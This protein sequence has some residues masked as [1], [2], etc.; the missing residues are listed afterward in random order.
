MTGI[1]VARNARAV[2]DQYKYIYGAKGEW[3]SVA[4]VEELIRNSP[5]YFDSESKK[6]AARANAGYSCADCSGYVSICCGLSAQSTYSLYEMA[7]ERRILTFSNGTWLADGHKIPYGAILW[8][9]KH[10]GIY[11]GGQQVVEARS[12]ELNVT[13]NSLDGR[14]FTH[15]LLLRGIQYE[16]HT[17]DEVVMA[18]TAEGYIPWIGK[19]INVDQV[20]PSLMYPPT[21][22]AATTGSLH[23][24][25]Q[26]TIV[27]SIG[28]YYKIRAVNGNTGYVHSYYV[29]YLDAPA[30]ENEYLSWNGT[31][32]GANDHVNVRTGPGVE[33]SL[34]PLIQE[35]P[36][37]SIVTV[38]GENI[39]TNDHRIWY[40]VTFM[41]NYDGYIRSDLI[42]AYSVV[43]YSNWYGMA[44]SST[45]IVNIRV[46]ATVNSS[47][48]SLHSAL[49]N[50][51]KVTVVNEISGNDGYRWYQIEIDGVNVGYCRS[52]LITPYVEGYYNEWNGK[53]NTTTGSA[54]IRKGPGTGYT[55]VE[56]S[57]YANGTSVHVVGEVL[58]TDGYIWYKLT[59]AGVYAGYVRCDLVRTTTG[60]DPWYATAN[61]ETGTLNI[62]IGPGTNYSLHGIVAN[63]SNGTKVKV[64]DQMCGTDGRV[65]Y[66]IL[67]RDMYIGYTRG[68]LLEPVNTFAYPVWTGTAN[69]TTGV[70]NVRSGPSTTSEVIGSYPQLVNGDQF[71]V[72]DQVSAADGYVWFKI[73]ILNRYV[74]FVRSDLVSH[75]MTITSSRDYASWGGYV[76]A[77][78]G[79]SYVNIRTGAGIGYSIVC[80][81]DNLTHVEVIGT[82]NG[83][84]GYSWYR[85]QYNGN[86]GYI[87]SDLVHHVAS[88]T[89]P[90]VVYSDG[91]KGVILNSTFLVER[92]VLEYEGPYLSAETLQKLYKGQYVTVLNQVQGMA[93]GK[94]C[95]VTAE[96]GS[97]GFVPF[98]VLKLFLKEVDCEADAND[99]EG[100]RLT[101]PDYAFAECSKCGYHI[102]YRKPSKQYDPNSYR[103]MASI[104][105][106]INSDE[107]YANIVL[108][109]ELFIHMVEDIETAFYSYYR[110]IRLMEPTIPWTPYG[111]KVTHLFCGLARHLAYDDLP[112]TIVMLGNDFESGFVNSVE[113]GTLLEKEIRILSTGN[114]K[115]NC[116]LVDLGNW[117]Y[118]K[119]KHLMATLQGYYQNVIGAFDY[120]CGWGADLAT[121]TNNV[122]VNGAG[123]ELN[124]ASTVM[125]QSNS[126]RDPYLTYS[127]VDSRFHYEDFISDVD[128]IGLAKELDVVR[129]SEE[130]HVFSRCFSHYYSEKVTERKRNLLQDIFGH[131]YNGYPNLEELANAVRVKE[132]HEFYDLTLLGVP[133]EYYRDYTGAPIVSV[134]SLF[135]KGQLIGGIT[136]TVEAINA[137]CFAFAKYILTETDDMR[138]N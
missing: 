126:I 10:V 91:R 63:I 43:N 97:R 95:Q 133:E 2:I 71:D 75:G 65:W 116:P 92:G 64:T 4:H 56:G 80:S 31:V 89:S 38:M 20:T 26:I 128:A 104:A 47:M 99:T 131:D 87:R 108:S 22:V 119:W 70:V 123:D 13:M 117:G 118:F 48:S 60:Y 67:V 16:E 9:N 18:T 30:Y 132:T 84:D 28:E 90:Y 120:W 15:C 23:N 82:E 29:G 19:I 7:Y 46:E 124:C 37:G 55:L 130:C 36:N 83:A 39:G 45:G 14:G 62:R 54:N 121:M 86:A 93:T 11:V 44:N 1:E 58:S 114:D 5:S 137:A 74:G 115:D 98:G 122:V 96:D 129:S 59:V 105:D 72:I 100:H 127:S 57:P 109:F 73:R 21:S 51:D 101:Y 106:V 125:G 69:S 12:E 78:G 88:T 8:K 103:I 27:G 34:H 81:I 50:G 138:M 25:V 85:V 111:Q 135:G 49:S 17:G 107:N 68:D 52:D 35:L 102:E 33:Y 3:C 61:T 134:M 94:W 136:P 110:Q 53:L 77:G 41:G 40:H 112:W 113:N 42:S 66:K 32:H 79:N 24:G 6:A 76:Q